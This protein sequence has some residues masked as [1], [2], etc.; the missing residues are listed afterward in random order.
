MDG[1]HA[2]TVCAEVTRLAIQKSYEQLSLMGV[3]LE[4]SLLKPNMVLPGSDFTPRPSAAEVGLWT[5][6]TLRRSVPAA[7]PGIMFLS[8]G[9]S[10]EEATVHLNAINQVPLA[11]PWSLTFS[12][13]RALQASVLKAWKGDSTKVAAAQAVLLE[14]AKANSLAQL[15]KYTGG[16]GGKGATESLFQKDYVY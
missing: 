10:E 7:V 6:R 14:R 2:I 15:G 16:A 9:Q 13:G 8:G 11:K 4:G 1:D 12:Y 3:M 5:V